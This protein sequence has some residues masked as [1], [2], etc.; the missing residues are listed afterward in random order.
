MKL[1][2]KRT[3]L[4]SLLLGCVG[5]AGIIPRA[6]PDATEYKRE[7]SFSFPQTEKTSIGDALIEDIEKNPGKSGF[8]IFEK[9]SQSLM[10][11]LALVGL[12]ERSL[13]LQ[14][15]GIGGDISSHL[16]MKALLLAAERGVRVRLL[17]DS[18]TVADMR[19]SL[20]VLENV[21][22]I[23]VRVFNPMTTRDQS[24]VSKVQGLFSDIDYVNKRM[25]NKAFIADNQI[26]LIGG[27]N[28][29]DAY[30]EV[31]EDLDFKDLDILTAGPITNSISESF[32]AYWNNKNA[33]PIQMVHEPSQNKEER[34]K[35]IQ[36]LDE[37]WAIGI[38][39]MRRQLQLMAPLQ[40]VLKNPD[41][42]LTWAAAELA[43]D[44]PSKVDTPRDENE[45]DPLN[46]LVSLLKRAQSEFL[47]ISAYFVPLES[48]VKWLAGLEQKGIRN[49][50]DAVRNI[51]SGKYL[52]KGAEKQSTVNTGMFH[53]I[54]FLRFRTIGFC[55]FSSTRLK[56]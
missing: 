22:N 12:A 55:C 1:F 20:I 36:R 25:H 52:H 23:E 40:D 10:A 27:R 26:A 49:T 35:L 47:V 41:M 15:Y 42:A 48:G 30:F 5:C 43:V 2:L 16:M 33:F 6:R 37:D 32:D 45:S 11:R 46:K 24:L 4:F 56:K 17:I 9:G 18:F 8:R 51:L 38:K 7:T 31:D 54:Q 50:K 28:V 34:A 21:A 13:D 44:D 29:S 53:R 19:D 3:L 39:D 14:Y